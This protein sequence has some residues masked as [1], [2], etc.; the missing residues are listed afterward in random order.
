MAEIT[1]VH[2]GF[3]E[4]GRAARRAP[5]RRPFP[6]SRALPAASR[7]PYGGTGGGGGSGPVRAPPRGGCGGQRRRPGPG[8]GTERCLRRARPGLCSRLPGG[9]GAAAP[10][11]KAERGGGGGAG[12]GG[13]V[14]PR[15][16]PAAFRGAA[17]GR[18][19]G[20]GREAAEPRGIIRPNGPDG[21]G[22][23]PGSAL[24]G[25]WRPSVGSPRPLK[26]RLL[27]LLSS[28]ITD[29]PSAP[30]GRSLPRGYRVCSKF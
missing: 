3:G 1:S 25:D 26:A 30:W 11:P 10:P 18:G 12:W 4:W 8:P 15:P 22:A 5:F 24:S 13:A 28:S 21:R 23:A 14:I 17:A 20:G 16:P 9:R 19:G 29:L 7:P 2:P 6:R 27:L